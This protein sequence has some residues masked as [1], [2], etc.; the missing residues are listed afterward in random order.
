MNLTMIVPSAGSGGSGGGGG[1]GGGSGDLSIFVGASGWLSEDLDAHD[2]YIVLAIY[3]LPADAE[4]VWDV[5]IDDDLD[6]FTIV[7]CLTDPTLVIAGP[8][9]RPAP[10]T[11]SATVNGTAVPAVS[12]EPTT[13]QQ[14]C[15]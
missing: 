9:N 15:S 6:E 1:G 5:S 8:K 14:E 4:V 12:I 10:I 3:G 2:G 11:A 7:G 13:N